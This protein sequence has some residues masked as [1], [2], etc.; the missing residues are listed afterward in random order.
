M[1]HTLYVL[2]LSLDV[3]KLN[4]ALIMLLVAY[5]DIGRILKD[6]GKRAINNLATERIL[7]EASEMMEM[8]K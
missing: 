2:A 6:F 7:L 8:G 4:C 5:K 1:N 3:I